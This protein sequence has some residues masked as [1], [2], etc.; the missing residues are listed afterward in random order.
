M[1]DPK[2]RREIA[3]RAAQLMYARQES[4]Y[5]TAK[6]KAA[7]MVIGD[8]R[9]RDLPSNAEIRSEILL[10]AD[11]LEGDSRGRELESMRLHALRLMRFLKRFKPRLIGSVLTG[12]IRK[13]SD[14][15]LHLFT[16]SLGGVEDVLIEMGLAYSVE[17]KRVMKHNVERV[18]THIHVPNVGAAKYN[19]ELT[20]YTAD[21]ANYPF[22]SSI[23]GKVMERAGIDELEALLNQSIPDLE[24]A[25]ADLDNAD[26][27]DPFELFRL[28]LIP[29]EKVKQS[30]K[31]HPEGDALFHSLQ[32]FN[33][34]RHARSYDEEFLLAALLHDVGKAIDPHDHVAAGCEALEGAVTER[35]LWLVGHHM[36]AHEY[37]A[38]TLGHRA[39]RRLAESEWL[40]DLLLLSEVDQAGRERGVVVP[41]IEE[42]L[43]FIRALDPGS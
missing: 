5:F 14:I 11:M 7:R 12:H 31:F 10:L 20:I 17:H 25:L 37:R 23:T 2:I 33:L 16:D 36:E 24:A 34:A 1:S 13:G 6:R 22:K 4:E 9:F 15:D 39:R 35:T 42:V 41:T 29:L 26:N 19:V 28:L 40:E 21:K 18:F 43:D 38:G 3:L 32:V 27:L 30:P 8:D